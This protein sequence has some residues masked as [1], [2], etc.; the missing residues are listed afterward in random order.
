MENFYRLLIILYVCR[1][2][3][4]VDHKISLKKT[5][6]WQSW[7]YLETAQLRIPTLTENFGIKFGFVLYVYS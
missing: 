4:I 3:S 2:S 1:M 6:I 5:Y 7:L